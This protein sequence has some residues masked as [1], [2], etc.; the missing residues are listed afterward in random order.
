[1][2]QETS[3]VTFVFSVLRREIALHEACKSN[4]LE[5]VAKI[6]EEKIDINCKNNV[7]PLELCEL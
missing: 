1:M 5:A 4:K 3:H 7:R 2:L 6:L